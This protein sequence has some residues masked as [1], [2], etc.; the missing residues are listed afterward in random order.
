M[1]A[2]SF[3]RSWKS[4]GLV[5]GTSA[6]L[7][8]VPA[9]SG[10]ASAGVLP[11]SVGSLLG[12]VTSSLPTSSVPST[13][14]L[15]VVGPVLNT[16]TSTVGSAGS[17]SSTPLPSVL[18]VPDPTGVISS[19]VGTITNALPTSSGVPGGN[20]TTSVIP[21]L[22]SVP[23]LPGQPVN[24]SSNGGGPAY[25]GSFSGGGY[26]ASFG[27]GTDATP[28]AFS[29]GTLAGGGAL[30]FTGE[31]A[32]IHMVAMIALM[33]AFAIGLISLGL[34]FAARRTA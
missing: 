21:A 3:I 24:S 29:S 28:A 20:P 32:W 19:V 23:G 1:S 31:P 22:P 12:G 17:T 14:S 15:P 13:S 2:K 30:P 5:L 10:A 33:M 7:A 27:S 8:V 16:V 4:V 6:A 9:A 25:E 18:S 34:R 11:S 26:D